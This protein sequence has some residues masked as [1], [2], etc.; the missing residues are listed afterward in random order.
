M[1]EEVNDILNV[2]QRWEPLGLLEGLPIR[3]KT[4]LAQI[5]DNATRLLISDRAIKKIPEDIM[6]VYDSIYLPICR[7]LYK[8]VGPYFNLEI[9]MGKLLEVVNEKGKIILNVDPEKPEGNP[10]VDFCVDFADSYEDELTNKN[11]LTEEE[12][13]NKIEELTKTLKDILLN[14]SMVSY[15]DKKEGEYN[16]NLSKSKRTTQQIR[17]W[18]QSIA[19]NLLSSVLS[20]INKGF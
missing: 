1:S 9:M 15:V 11:T 6:E 17:F 3:E 2:V 10:V 4:E 16:L 19:K 8:R 13:Q 7:R 20:E 18:N 5:Y 12:Y 14:S